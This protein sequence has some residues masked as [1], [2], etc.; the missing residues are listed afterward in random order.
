[1][2]SG[3]LVG[4]AMSEYEMHVLVQDEAPA[5]EG[6]PRRSAPALGR[7]TF[8]TRALTHTQPQRV[9]DRHAALGISLRKDGDNRVTRDSNVIT[10]SE[11]QPYLFYD[12]VEMEDAQVAS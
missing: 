8:S 3:P 7:S 4:A 11:E 2:A 6:N 10:A 1:M 5:T 9:S 12:F